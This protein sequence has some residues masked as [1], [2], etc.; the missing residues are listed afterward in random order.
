[1][2][3]RK[4]ALCPHQAQSRNR[5]QVTGGVD[6]KTSRFSGLGNQDPAD[7]RT[8]EARSVENRGVERD[9]VAQVTFVLQQLDHERLARRNVESVDRSQNQAQSQKVPDLN[10]M[11]CGQKRQNQSLKQKQDLRPKDNLAA[12]HPVQQHTGKGRDE[13]R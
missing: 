8:D 13:K 4:F 9:R 5:S 1:S 6:V 2:F 12:V 10:E 7:R 3:H 11:T